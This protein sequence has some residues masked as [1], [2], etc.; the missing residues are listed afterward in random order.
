MVLNF[1]IVVIFSLLVL[2]IVVKRVDRKLVCLPDPRFR[3]LKLII[4]PDLEADWVESRFLVI[5]RA[6]LKRPSWQC[7]DI[8]LRFSSGRNI[9]IEVIH[10]NSLSLRLEAVS[11]LLTQQMFTF[12]LLFLDY[13][14]LL[15]QYVKIQCFAP[16]MNN[17][18]K[19]LIL[20]LFLK[21]SSIASR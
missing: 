19:R 20:K 17:R 18:C 16:L 2:I 12:L 13:S 3:G 14:I 15:L 6:K 5:Y 9:I 8:W 7:E 11:P 4:L 10:I 1:Q 21:Y